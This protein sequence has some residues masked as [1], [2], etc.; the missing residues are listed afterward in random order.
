VDLRRHDGAAVVPG[1]TMR[2][3]RSGYLSCWLLADAQAGRA[4]RIPPSCPSS[5]VAEYGGERGLCVRAVTGCAALVRPVQ[6]Q[7]TPRHHSTQ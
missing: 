5:A 4:Q 2:L 7:A 3:F 6:L 1:Q